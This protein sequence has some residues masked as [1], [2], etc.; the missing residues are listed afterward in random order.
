MRDIAEAAGLSTANLY[1]Y[2][3]SKQELLYWC[4]DHSL[5]RML[6]A[7]EQSRREP[8]AALRLSRVV[9]AHALCVLDELDGAAAHLEGLEALAPAARGRIA[10]RRD[11]YEEEIRA[12]I[13]LGVRRGEFVEC[14]AALVARAILGALNWTVR[15]WRPDGRATPPEIAEQFSEYLVRGLLVRRA[16]GRKK[17]TA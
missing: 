6:D 4:Q 5:R 9:R 14:D 15:W 1:Y 13:E 10:A 11:R 17:G 7:C 3:R 2:F 12:L 8:S 16:N